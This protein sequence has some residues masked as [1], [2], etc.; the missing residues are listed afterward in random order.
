MN[1]LGVRRSDR[2]L[3]FNDISTL[4]RHKR[5]VTSHILQFYSAVDNIGNYTP[6]LGIQKFLGFECDVWNIHR[7]PIDFEYINRTYKAIIIGGAGL[8]HRVF[9]GFWEEVAQSSHLPAVIWGVGGCFLDDETGSMAP[10][11]IVRRVASIASHVNVRDKLTAEYYDFH[12]ASIS[13]CPTV[14]WLQPWKRTDE[15]ARDSALYVSHPEL[16]RHDDRDAINSELRSTGIRYSFTDNIQRPRLG[17]YDIIN[18]LYRP[19]GVVITTRLHGAI[20]AAGLGI[21][22][23]ALARDEKVRAFAREWGGGCVIESTSD[24][25]PTLNGDVPFARELNPK[26]YTAGQ[27]FALT[28]RTWLNSL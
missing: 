8:L 13:P 23:I 20:I 2:R 19:A 6:I 5:R 16:E 17:L 7:T 25:A 3:A 28:V 27:E 22:Y 1:K 26:F 10:K 9:T 4:P 11:S 21:P 14:N 15:A 24:L 12:E 18:R